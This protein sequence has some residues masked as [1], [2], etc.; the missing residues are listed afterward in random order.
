MPNETE[1]YPDPTEVEELKKLICRRGQLKA[2]LTRFSTYLNGE[3]VDPISLK[4]RLSK[5]ESTWTEFEVVQ[6]KIELLKPEQAL[7]RDSFEDD[8]FYV[9]TKASKIVSSYEQSMNSPGAGVTNSSGSANAIPNLQNLAVS[10]TVTSSARLQAI[11]LPK[12]SGTYEGWLNFFEIFQALVHNNTEISTIQKF[13]YLQSCLTGEA[14]Q[15]LQSLEICEANYQQALDLLKERYQNKRLLIHNHVRNLFDIEPIIKES[16]QG[17]RKLIDNLMRNIRALASLNQ[18]VEHWDTILVYMISQ[19][20]D[21]NTRREWELFNKKD[22][23]TFQEFLEFLKNKCQVLE[24]IGNKEK[25]QKENVSNRYSQSKHSVNFSLSK[26]DEVTLVNQVNNKANTLNYNNLKCYFCNQVGHF[27][28]K[29]FKLVSLSCKD[30]LVELRKI[31]LC[32]NC[33]K[34]G[35]TAETCTGKRCRICNKKHNSMLHDFTYNINE[36]KP[37]LNNSTSSCNLVV[38]NDTHQ[39][40]VTPINKSNNSNPLHTDNTVAGESFATFNTCTLSNQEPINTSYSKTQV[41]LP[42]AVI[43]V[44][45][46]NNKWFKCRALLDSASQ[47]NF[48]SSRILQ[49]LNLT[50]KSVEIPVAG[51]N[52]I[53]SSILSKFSTTIKSVSESF[54]S[55]INILVVENITSRLPQMAFDI[56]QLKLPSNIRLADPSFGDSA[57]IDFLLGAEIFFSCLE[58][59]Q[60]KLGSRLPILQNTKFGWVLAGPL[61]FEMARNKSACFLTLDCLADNLL[62]NTVQKFWQIENIPSDRSKFS[63]EELDCEMHFRENVENDSSGRFIVKLPLRDNFTSL[64]ESYSIAARCFNSLDKKLSLNPNLKNSYKEFLNEYEQLEHMS[65]VDPSLDKPEDLHVYFSHHAV[66]RESSST[67][68]LRVVFNASLKTS[69]GLSLND[70]LKVGPKVQPDI[71]NTVLR[72]RTYLILLIADIEKMYRMILVHP[73]Q[74]KLQRILFRDPVSQKLNHYELNTITYGT[75]SA[76]FLATR[77][78]HEI[79]LRCKE[80]NPEISEIII[81]NFYMDDLI[82]GHHDVEHLN[83]LKQ[84]IDSTLLSYGFKL[85]KWLSNCNLLIEGHEGSGQDEFY[86]R[87]DSDTKTLGTVWKPADDTISYDFDVKSPSSSITKRTILASIGRLFDVLGLVSPVI[88]KAKL[89]LQSVWRIHLDWDEEVPNHLAQTWLNFSSKLSYLNNVQIPRCV[90]NATNPPEF[91]ALYGFSDASEL[92]YGACVYI[93]SRDTKG[94][95]SQSHLLCAKSRLAPMSSLSL[96]RLEL[97]GALLLAQLFNKVASTLK[98]SF[99]DVTLFTDSSIVLSWLNS[100]PNRWKVF[101]ANRVAEIQRLTEHCEWRHIDSKNNPADIVSRGVDPE[102]LLDLDLWWHGP[103]FMTKPKDEWPFNKISPVEV[104]EVRK[105]K[106]Q[107]SFPVVRKNVSTDGLF[108]WSCFSKTVRVYSYIRRFINNTRKTIKIQGPL[109]SI[110]LDETLFLLCNLVQSDHFSA[111]LV[112][113][114]KGNSV[115]R[116]SKLLSLTPFL[117]P[118]GLLRVGG[119]LSNS[120]LE[121]ENKHPIILPAKHIFTEM[122]IKYYHYKFLHAGPQFLLTQIRNKFWIINGRQVVRKVLHR[123]LT[124]FRVKPLSIKQIM[125]DL[126]ES[127]VVP[128]RPFASCGVD[129]AGPYLLKDGKTRNRV[130]IKCYVC[131]YICFTTRAVHAE[132]VSDLTSIAFMNSFKRFVSRRGLPSDIFSDNA[133]NFVGAN[134]DLT[135]LCKLIENT[136]SCDKYNRYFS[137]HK[138][139]WHFIPARSPHFGGLWESAVRSVK[140]HL[141]RVL[142]DCHLNFEEFYTLLNQVEAIL[143]SRPILPLSDDPTDMEVLTPA[144]FLIGGS[145]VAVPQS[146]VPDVNINRLQ[147]FKQIQQ[148][149]QRFWAIWSRD[150][151]NTLQQRSK[152]KVVQN[153]LKEGV[154]VLIKEDHEPPMHWPLGR[155]EAVHPGKDGYVRVASVRTK[156]GVCR[157]AVTRLCPLPLLD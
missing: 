153:N 86:I 129:Y 30:R 76:S 52:N 112:E 36:N 85:R 24:T 1:V 87:A 156:G 111:E 65:K 84:Q 139:N 41:L 141:K 82:F 151:L 101:V 78:L 37:N 138:I 68:K 110:E 44:L 46:N 6:S 11:S 29:C 23:P 18:P 145:L 130:L 2:T 48:C 90:L 119:R 53:T 32:T 93:V 147:R 43:N 57:E 64:G 142:G 117:D 81:N 35:H 114:K 5:L 67:T 63:K 50:T 103:E 56:S 16:A 75:A 55:N 38:Q 136:T 73:S 33:L 120:Q 124:C 40:C 26:P 132:L 61:D 96:P 115:P 13:Y 152:W 131:I 95:G 99:E 107:L 104:P 71:F 19:K 21:L 134:N 133:T 122:L 144:H 121:Y 31:G 58:G 100:E 7:E 94:G 42:T 106:L 72:M 66:L 126:P 127:R 143:N 77:V 3:E 62:Q 27:T 9:V 47:S 12:F 54:A 51:L 92:A 154:L 59:D 150:Y 97:C 155:V 146:R 28:Y 80:S 49:Q 128:S 74:R 34:P 123:C 79:G 89:I 14:V 113:I 10:N 137:E 8:Y 157:R 149:L 109:T 91:T 83:S 116:S 102:T 25:I 118:K 15:V 108:K 20:I 125:G 69:T 88:V 105:V 70:V 17:F 140:Y 98:F 135:K 4:L 45:G 22:A 148:M 60:I 39:Q